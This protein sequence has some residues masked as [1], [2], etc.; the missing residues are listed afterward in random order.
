MYHTPR[1]CTIQVNDTFRY[2]EEARIPI[3]QTFHEYIQQAKSWE[4][5]LMQHITWHRLPFEIMEYLIKQRQKDE[6]LL[7]VSDGSSLEQQTMSFGIVIGTS[8]GVIFL[9]AMGPASGETSSHRAE[10]TGCLAATVILSHLHRYTAIRIPGD[11]EVC[12][13]SDNQ[14]M[15]QSLQ[16]RAKY[17]TGYTNTTLATDWDLLE[18]IH[19]T[20]KTLALSSHGYKWVQGHQD[21]KTTTTLSV[22]AK[23]NVR[24][25]QL[26]GEY[27]H[28]VSRQMR[29]ATP[30]FHHTKCNFRIR[31]KS[32]N[33]K[34]IARIR[35]EAARAPY[36][37]YLQQR[38]GW[39][40]SAMHDIDWASFHTAARNYEG[41]QIQ[42]LKIVHDKLPTNL[43]R[44]RYIPSI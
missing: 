1:R 23:Y 36:E 6:K 4:Q 17:T 35:K 27:I 33:G 22:E 43:M 29:S 38:H 5:E 37:K 13:I 7:I 3:A 42:L 25:D 32:C 24:A 41:N 31:E 26:A 11:I 28:M 39:S 30:L 19:Q 20:Y 21:T 8:K 18:E 15:I 14:G 12:T 9:E 40:E 44:S 34:Y 2:V 10:C 16:E